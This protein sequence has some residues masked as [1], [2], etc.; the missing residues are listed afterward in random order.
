MFKRSMRAIRVCVAIAVPLASP[1][2][3]AQARHRDPEPPIRRLANVLDCD[4]VHAGALP[5][6]AVPHASYERLLDEPEYAAWVA[7]LRDPRQPRHHVVQCAHDVWVARVH[8][9][10]RRYV[11]PAKGAL[12]DGFVAKSADKI[13]ESTDA[14]RSQDQ[15]RDPGPG[16]D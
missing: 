3:P 16:Q 13:F 2:P 4:G 12:Y 11:D 14:R 10:A 5:G 8:E 1:R 15:G 7:V 9:F 6:P